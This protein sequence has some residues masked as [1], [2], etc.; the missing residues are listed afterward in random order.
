MP[1]VRKIEQFSKLSRPDQQTLLGAVAALPVIRVGLRLMG[2]PRIHAMLQLPPGADRR[3]VP[4]DD[5]KA[6]AGVVDIASRHTLGTS[7][8]L[9]RSLLLIWLLRRRGVQSELRIGVRLQ[10]GMAAHAWVELDGIPVNDQA[11]IRLA[12]LPFE[13]S[14]PLNAFKTR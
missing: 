10:G 8:C 2:L 9:T 4:L 7:T 12:F 1:G 6:L 11:G 14:L 13:E 3:Q 5:V